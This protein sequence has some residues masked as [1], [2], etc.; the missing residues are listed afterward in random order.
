[1]AWQDFELD[2]QRGK[3]SSWHQVIPAL[4]IKRY[5]TLESHFVTNTD[6]VVALTE[7]LDARDMMVAER[8]FFSLFKQLFST[9]QCEANV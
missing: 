9:N 4:L 5:F 1:M 2:L 3:N 8:F 7:L 6:S